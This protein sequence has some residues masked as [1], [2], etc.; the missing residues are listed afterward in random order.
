MMRDCILSSIHFMSI[1]SCWMTN[2]SHSSYCW[3]ISG[4]ISFPWAFYQYIQ[5]LWNAKFLIEP[6]F[7]ANIDWQIVVF[8]KL[9]VKNLFRTIDHSSLFLKV[10][11]CLSPSAIKFQT[12][13]VLELCDTQ[14]NLRMSISQSK[15]YFVSFCLINNYTWTQ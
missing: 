9:Q 7:E 6:S 13:L 15:G 11:S 4:S 12:R 2:I 14:W 10:W 3:L 5:T 1:I 8:F